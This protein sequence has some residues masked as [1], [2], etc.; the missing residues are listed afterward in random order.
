MP[1][2]K[3]DR[4]RRARRAAARAGEN[5]SEGPNPREEAPSACRYLDR[6]SLGTL[7]QMLDR[8]DLT[9]TKSRRKAATKWGDSPL[10]ESDLAA[11]DYS[12]DSIAVPPAGGAAEASESL[13]AKGALG[14]R[15]ERSGLYEVADYNVA[16]A[17]D[18]DD[19]EAEEEENVAAS[20]E[21]PAAENRSVL[22]SF[23]SRLSLSTSRDRPLTAE[24]L[25]PTIAAMQQHLMSKNV[26]RDI[27]EQIVASVGKSLEGKTISGGGAGSGLAGSLFGDRKG[28]RAVRE[29][30]QE[31]LV[32]ILTPKTSTDLLLE[33]QR[34]R[35]AAAASSALSSTSTAGAGADPY[36]IT[37]VGVNGVGKSTNLSKVAFWLLQNRLRVLIAACDTFRSGAVEQLRVHVRNLGRLEEE[38]GGGGETQEGKSRVELF[39]KGYGKDAAGI[40]KDAL[41][42]GGS[43]P[44]GH[45]LGDQLQATDFRLSWGR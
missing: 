40:A 36:A 43:S 41:A 18:D 11:Y 35:S 44:F 4:K 9:P 8:S 39:E 25:A 2:S 33:I 13:V 12:S 27:A 7:T 19:E 32:R 42:H 21:A 5:R 22:S 31:A 14:R 37:F 17:D 16:G 26:A 30:L 38:L 45:G 28:K 6:L 20:D 29:A 3:R 24:D 10:T 34:K 15:D 1:P 23:F